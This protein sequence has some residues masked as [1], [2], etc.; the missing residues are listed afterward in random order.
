MM[1]VF[2]NIKGGTGKSTLAVHVCVALMMRGFRVVTVDYDGEQGT[3]SRY[4]ENRERFQKQSGRHVPMPV[5]HMRLS[6]QEE[7][8]A[9]EEI[10]KKESKETYIIADTPGYDCPLSRYA[11]GIADVLVTPMNESG[12]DLDLLVNVWDTQEPHKLPLSQYATMVWEQR[13]HKASQGISALEWLVVR[14]RL[15]A[16]QSRNQMAID[17]ILTSLARRIGFHLVGGMSERVIFRELFLY[18]LTVMDDLLG[19]AQV[20]TKA[21]QEINVLTEAILSFCKKQAGSIMQED[22]SSLTRI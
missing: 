18:G 4:L 9:L 5:Y 11:H 19:Q 12:I 2:G 1:I 20:Y 7:A 13:M 22:L 21:R 15:H 14:N 8:L 16:L 10:L 6:S 17:K 3:L